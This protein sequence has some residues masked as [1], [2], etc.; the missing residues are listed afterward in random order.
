MNEP[1]NKVRIYFGDVNNFVDKTNLQNSYKALRQ[2][3]ENLGA[4]SLFLLNQV[5]GIEGLFI[6]DSFLSSLKSDTV[7]IN[8][9]GD[10]LYTNVSGI[11]LGILTA[12]CL[13][14]IVY[15]SRKKAVLA[16]HAGWRGS[17]N[18]IIKIAIKQFCK[19]LDLYL[20][21]LNFHFGP[22]AKSCCYE[23]GIDFVSEFQKQYKN[24]QEF[25]IQKSNKFFFDLVKFNLLTLISIGINSY[26]INL[27]NNDCTICNLRFCSYRR[28]KSNIRN[29]NF[30]T[31]S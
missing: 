30:V 22:C 19:D 25:I 24:W 28:L 16:I 17:L 13:P 27:D 21:D 31:I 20:R 10:F 12:D 5:H 18:Q 3:R 29:I 7:F 2:T 4:Q 11:A 23:V 26:D 9:A 6:N 15:D 14:I 8:E 1:E